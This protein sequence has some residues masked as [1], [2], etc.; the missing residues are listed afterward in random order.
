MNTSSADFKENFR[1]FVGQD[2][3]D[4]IT[5]AISA[6]HAEQQKG[7][8]NPKHF[9]IKQLGGRTEE[10]VAQLEAAVESRKAEVSALKAR[11]E[12][13]NTAK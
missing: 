13:N 7:P 6:L 5:R 8:C 1:K 9:V 2:T 12:A 10:E 3:V 4:K 11:L